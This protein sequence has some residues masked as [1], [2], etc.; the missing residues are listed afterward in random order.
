MLQ[1][2]LSRRLACYCNQT[3]TFK[4]LMKK[5]K[6]KFCYD[7]TVGHPNKPSMYYFSKGNAGGTARTPL[8]I[9]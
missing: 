8:N 5:L 6:R 4:V 3:S 9:N 1:P 2:D 7:E